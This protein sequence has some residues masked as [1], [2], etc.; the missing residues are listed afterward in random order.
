VN[1]EF[2]FQIHAMY[3]TPEEEQ[4]QQLAD[5]VLGVPHEKDLADPEDADPMDDDPGDGPP[6]AFAWHVPE[7]PPGFHP[8]DLPP[9]N[10]IP[11]GYEGELVAQLDG[12]LAFFGESGEDPPL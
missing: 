5:D 9:A 2:A 3:W 4:L 12:A 8:A 7:D 6:L 11:M 1:F 10:G